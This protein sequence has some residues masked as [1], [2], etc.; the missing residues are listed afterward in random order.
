MC[1][2]QL[3]LET[4]VRCRAFFPAWLRQGLELRVVRQSEGNRRR[5][6]VRDVAV[7]VRPIIIALNAEHPGSDLIIAAALHAT[8]GAACRV[9]PK[10]SESWISPVGIGP[11]ASGVAADAKRR[12]GYSAT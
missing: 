6:C 10:I 3:D 9:A 5:D 1:R 8:Q 4:L 12:D 2:A 11:N 7:D